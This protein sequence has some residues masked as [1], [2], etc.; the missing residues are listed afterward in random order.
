MYGTPLV[1]RSLHIFGGQSCLTLERHTMQTT[2]KRAAL[3]N[4]DELTYFAHKMKM[5]I[6]LRQPP[7]SKIE[8]TYFIFKFMV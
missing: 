5:K 6:F 8:H 1:H 4:F 3:K 7:F 2:S